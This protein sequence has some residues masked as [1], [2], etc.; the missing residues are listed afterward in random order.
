MR[1]ILCSLFLPVY[2]LVALFSCDENTMGTFSKELMSAKFDGNF[3]QSASDYTI[4]EDDPN[5][6]GIL[7]VTGTKNKDF[8]TVAIDFERAEIKAGETY[9]CKSGSPSVITWT[10]RNLVS[11]TTN[12][13]GG[14]GQLKIT[15]Y[16]KKA[17]SGTFSVIITDETNPSRK[18]I[19]TEG[20]FAAEVNP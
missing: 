9:E 15:Y 18:I 6:F 7:S 14:S 4:G 19:L 17:I 10:D 13:T 5:N 2:L 3:W 20:K 8:L 16:D 12:N 11:Y 1:T